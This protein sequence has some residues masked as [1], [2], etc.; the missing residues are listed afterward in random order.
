MKSTVTAKVVAVMA[1]SLTACSQ[2]EG[3]SD[4][5][6][7]SD[8][9]AARAPVV[10]ADGG[11]Y[12]LTY[13][14][15]EGGFATATAIEEVPEGRR[16]AVRIQDPRRPP[17]G[18]DKL[19]VADL[20][21]PQ[22]GRYPVQ[23]MRRAEFLALAGFGRPTKA[24]ADA[25]ASPPAEAGTPAARPRVV[26]YMSS[27]CPVCRRARRWLASHD[28][29]FVERNIERDPEAAAEL[30]QKARRAGISANGVPVFDIGGRMIAGFDQ[31]VL[32][33]ALGL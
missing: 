12:V 22:S 9:G 5:A 25:G 11:P 29:S 4:E 3:D 10:T 7:A 6:T 8:G 16:Q 1:L 23:E 13:V 30:Q 19:W 18:P 32:S 24:A 2:T 21:T 26:M 14:D 17:E 33:R 15:D 27:S 28:V 31:G 20:R